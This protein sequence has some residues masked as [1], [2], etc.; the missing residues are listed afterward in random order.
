[1]QTVWQ[2]IHYG[3]KLLAKN[4]G[5]TAV[6]V[7]SLALGIGLNSTIFCLVDRIIL[8]P[9]PV[10]RPDQLVTIKI[11]TEKGSASNSLAYPNYLELRSESKSLSGIIGTQYHGALLSNG[12]T[13]ELIPSEVSTRNYFTVL[14]VRPYV[15]RFFSDADND[16][17]ETVAVISY[18]L[19]Q[20][21][22]GANPEIVG[23]TIEISRRQVTLIGVAPRGFGG[24]RRPATT[25]DVW[26]PAERTGSVLTGPQAE[27]F[28]LLGRLAPGTSIE[29][30]NAEVDTIVRRLTPISPNAEKIVAGRLAFEAKEYSDRF[31]ILGFSLMAIAG[32]IL[33]IA[34]VNVSNLLLARSQ[35]RRKEIAIRVAIG[36]SRLRLIRQLLTESLVLSL[37]AAAIGFL[38]TRWTTQALPSFLP[39]MPIRLIPEISPDA[40]VLGFAAGLAF[41]TTLIFALIPALHASKLD[42]VPLLNEPAGTGQTGRRY[43]GRSALVIGQL[44]IS[45]VLLTQSGLLAK[46][47]LRGLQA[48]VGFE[49]KDMLVSQFALGMYEYDNNQAKAFFDGLLER[50]QALPGVRHVSLAAR[51]PLSFAGGGRTQQVSIP[52]E[53][54]LQK[55]KYNMVGLNYFRTMGTRILKGRDFTS[56]DFGTGIRAVLVSEAFERRFWPAADPIAQVIQIGEPPQVE[57]AT[58]VGVVQ[59]GPINYIGEDPV[60]YMYLPFVRRLDNDVTVLAETA[61]DPRSFAG[62]FRQTVHALD[63]NVMPYL[64]TTLKAT[65]REGLFESEIMAS[66]MGAFGLLG[67]T[68]ASFGLYGIVSYSAAQRTREIG[69]R[70]AL[71]ARRSDALRMVLSH[72]LKLALAGTVIGLPIAVAVSYSMRTAFYHVSPAD[73]SAVLGTAFLLTAVALLASYIPA[74]R[75]TRVD[76]MTALRH[77]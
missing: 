68:L 14:G 58:I 71:G 22:F 44:C 8:R 29:K 64:V 35:A 28:E 72:G 54:A 48:D 46:S 59:D 6:A 37:V 67:L 50:L 30:A 56:Q 45:L 43:L 10:D 69:L 53:K 3:F 26:Y 41:L 5:F 23:K 61:G 19:W 33:L 9:L 49:K 20:R 62:P 36:G 16:L 70:M 40:R 27:D 74:R 11:R 63:K 12:Q 60:L 77:Q 73:P 75:A 4:P 32:L 1:M 24:I 76:P 55:I 47:L 7:F 51:V 21:R 65:V 52:G 13:S 15:G 39:A 18:G 57:A 31:G 25:T 42:L 38:L 17:A 66:F 34:C 2:D